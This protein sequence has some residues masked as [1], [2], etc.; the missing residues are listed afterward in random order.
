MRAVHRNKQ[1]IRRGPGGRY[2]AIGAAVL[3]TIGAVFYIRA[4]MLSPLRIARIAARALRQGDVET[5][6][7]LTSRKERESLNLT[8]STVD[9]CLREYDRSGR[10]ED[11][12]FTIRGEMP[13]YSDVILCHAYIEGPR[14]DP[15][16]RTC[17]IY[18]YQDANH[19]WRLG[20]SMLLFAIHRAR[21]DFPDGDA[22]SWDAVARRSG[23]IGC[24]IPGGPT[25]FAVDG[26]HS[27]DL[28]LTTVE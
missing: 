2:V 21:R 15:K 4:Y 8:I 7:S 3:L 6:L 23:I 28:R 18:I 16:R 10:A 24:T 12:R 22:R 20:L 13:Y 14:L 11:V 26:S 5:L 1:V 27:S 17:D 9:A 25:R 19:R